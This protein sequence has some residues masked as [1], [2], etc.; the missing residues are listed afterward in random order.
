[1]NNYFNISRFILI[2]RRDMYENYKTALGGLLTI[3]S[4]F[5]VILL[6]V[7]L[8]SNQDMVEEFFNGLFIAGFF[9]SGL[10]FSGMAFKDF[11]NKEKSMTY[12]MLPAS[13]IEKFLS[14]LTLSTI[15]FFISYLLIFSLFNVLNILII[16]SLPF[17]LYLN[18][19][20]PFNKDIWA[21]IKIFL[22]IQAVFLAGAATFKK[23][24]IFYTA[25]FSFVTA[26]IMF[27]ILM[28]VMRYLATDFNISGFGNVDNVKITHEAETVTA[29]FSEIIPLY[30]MKIF[31]L[32]L[33]TPI[34]WVVAWFKIKEKEV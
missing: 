19:Y 27:T 5:T 6:L 13:Q 22:P 32:Y 26:L 16:G 9:I 24:P 3:L 10:F 34:F 29:E 21:A 30:L 11:R 20:N 23:V 17:D 2:L 4:I 15:G 7:S 25:L 18:M 12:L 1:M 14:I 8:N 31:F 33:M 28:L